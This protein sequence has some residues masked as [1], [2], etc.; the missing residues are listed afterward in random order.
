MEAL[1]V[2]ILLIILVSLGRR[3]AVAAT[4]ATRNAGLPMQPAPRAAMRRRVTIGSRARRAF[5][6]GETLAPHR[7]RELAIY[8]RTRA[9]VH[10]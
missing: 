1:A 5:H 4:N 9:L 6:A 10:P 3:K 2:F 8:E 7:Q